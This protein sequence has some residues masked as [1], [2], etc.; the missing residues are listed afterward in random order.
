MKVV[1]FGEAPAD[2]KAIAILVRGIVGP[3]IVEFAHT[4]E[5]H[6]WPSVL[7]MVNA[8]SKTTDFLLACKGI[9]YPGIHFA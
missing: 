6:G 8:V 3:A 1:F 4:F 2:Q 9:P 7:S 5:G